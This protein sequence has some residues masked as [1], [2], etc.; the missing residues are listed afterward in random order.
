MTPPVR[1]GV[2]PYLG[3]LRRSRHLV[4]SIDAL[5]RSGTAVVVEVVDEPP[6]ED[7]RSLLAVQLGPTDP[8]PGAWVLCWRVNFVNAE[9]LDV[10]AG[11]AQVSAQ[12]MDRVVRG[13]RAVIEP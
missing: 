3:G 5:N 8:S 13:V 10:G 7:L 9:R 12:T 2:Y 6:P 11:S 1:G 4:V